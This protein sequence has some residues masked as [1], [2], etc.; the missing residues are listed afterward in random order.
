MGIHND[1]SFEVADESSLSYMVVAFVVVRDE[2]SAKFCQA[3]GFGA[4]NYELLCS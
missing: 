2:V 4:V 3:N 1:P